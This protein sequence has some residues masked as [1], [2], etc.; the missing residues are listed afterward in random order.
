M[1]ILKTLKWSNWF[2]YGED[3]YINLAEY[4]LTQ[5]TGVN[6]SGKSSIPL[7]I[8]EI[9]YGK[10]SQGKKK[11]QLANRYINK[12]ISAVL[13]FSQHN[14]EYEIN[15]NR[16]STLSLKL[17]ENGKD[18]SSHSSTN[19]YKTISSILGK[20]HKTLSQLMYQSSTSNLEFL[21]ATDVTRKR[22]L[23]GLFNLNRYLDIHEKFKKIFTEVNSDLKVITGQVNTIQEWIDKYSKEDLEL[24]TPK[25]IPIIN[26]QDINKLADLKVQKLTIQETNKKI[27]DNNSFKELRNN[28]DLNILS[29]TTVVPNISEELA[30]SKEI[31][32]ETIEKKSEIRAIQTNKNKISS[33]GDVCH[34]CLQPISEDNRNNILERY[35]KEIDSINDDLILLNN[36]MSALAI[37]IENAAEAKKIVD[38]RN[39]ISNELSKLSILIHDDIPNEIIDEQQLL[40]DIRLLEDEVHFTQINIKQLSEQNNKISAHNSKV[41]VIKEQLA[42]YDIQLTELYKNVTKYTDLCNR[43]DLLKKAFSPSGLLNYKVEYLIKDLEK[44]INIYL[45][46]FSNG[47]FQLVF[48]LKEDKLNINILDDGITIEIEELSAGELARIN[49][50]TL[51]AIRKLMAAISSTK[52]NILFLDEIMGILDEEGK[53]KLIEILNKES[54]LNTFLVSHEFSHPLIPKINVIKEN[55]ISRIEK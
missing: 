47:R 33:L 42:D 25:I 50:S 2:S 49:A 51:L 38:N 4:P 44:Q 14:N 19:T 16:K 5:I 11:T 13:T 15:Y 37:Q 34:T 30:R 31:Q 45:T 9:L 23:I 39:K 6:G 18:I 41:K 32:K 21:T 29:D 27:N 43:I 10:N 8:E 36:E 17:F 52:L 12:P 26:K 55:K 54:D 20:D 35:T 48:V 28:L 53:D 7:I 40:E 24:K 46:E 3:N 1:I 22:F